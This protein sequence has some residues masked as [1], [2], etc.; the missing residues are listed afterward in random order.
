MQDIRFGQEVIFTSNELCTIAKNV[1]QNKR[2][3]SS[4][5]FL[6]VISGRGSR[7]GRD[8][9]GGGANG[10]GGSFVGRLVWT[11]L[12]RMTVLATC[13]AH[14]YGI[15]LLF[16]RGMHW[17]RNVCTFSQ[18]ASCFVWKMSITPVIGYG[19]VAWTVVLAGLILLVNGRW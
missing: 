13:L 5:R 17:N 11:A 9:A 19:T 18:D 2:S 4:H 10:G 12:F 8:A 3:S 16:R 6:R 7:G 14:G 15:L 1:A